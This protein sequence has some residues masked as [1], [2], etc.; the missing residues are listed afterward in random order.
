[1]KN[2]WKHNLEK[3]YAEALRLGLNPNRSDILDFHNVIGLLHT[4]NREEAFRY[5]TLNSRCLPDLDWT[6]NVVGQLVSL[7][8]LRV[9]YI[10]PTESRVAVKMD[11]VIKP[12]QSNL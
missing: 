1:M 9:G 6:R 8:E 7:V 3:I 4:G 5:F 11:I 2:K 12:L 10:L